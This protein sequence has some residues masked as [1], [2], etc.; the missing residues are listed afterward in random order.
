MLPQIFSNGTWLL[1]FAVFGVIMFGA[2]ALMS[3]LADRDERPLERLKR[4]DPLAARD[5]E[6]PAL[7]RNDRVQEILEMAA[8]TLSKPLMPKT[9]VEQS[10]LRLRLASAGWRGES[11]IPVYLGLKLLLTLVG[12]GLSAVVFMSTRG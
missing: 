5:R 8:P 10:Q 1:G 11:A 4:L 9:A 2:W 7:R 6:S 3:I 12:A